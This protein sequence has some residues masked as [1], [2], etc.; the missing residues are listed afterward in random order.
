MNELFFIARKKI[1]MTRQTS[2]VSQNKLMY[3]GRS[4]SEVVVYSRQP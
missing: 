4:S 1:T 2:N 3:N